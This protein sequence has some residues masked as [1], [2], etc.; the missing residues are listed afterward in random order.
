MG[1][2]VRNRFL[3]LCSRVCVLG[4]VFFFFDTIAHSQLIENPIGIQNPEGGFESTDPW[5]DSYAIQ[6]SPEYVALHERIRESAGYGRY[7]HVQTAGLDA[8]LYSDGGLNISF[9][10]EMGGGQL[11]RANFERTEDAHTVTGTLEFARAAAPDDCFQHYIVGL[12]S[13]ADGLSGYFAFGEKGY[14][15]RPAGLGRSV[16]YEFNA[17][18]AQTESCASCDHS[19][20]CDS[21]LISNSKPAEISIHHVEEENM[22]IRKF[23]T[24]NAGS[25][26]V[27]LAVGFTPEIAEFVDMRAESAAIVAQ[28]NHA[29][30]C[31]GVTNFCYRLSGYD[32]L[33]FLM[34]NG[35]QYGV[36]GILS[37]ILPPTEADIIQFR[38]SNDADQVLVVKTNNLEPGRGVSQLETAPIDRWRSVVI[39][40]SLSN[41]TPSHELAHNHGCQHLENV[42]TGGLGELNAWAKSHLIGP[43]GT[44]IMSASNPLPS[45][46]VRT[47]NFSNPDEWNWLGQTGLVDR[48]NAK[49]LRETGCDMSQLVDSYDPDLSQAIWIRPTDANTCPGDFSRFTVNDRCF[50]SS[51][52]TVSWSWSIN[53]GPFQYL[54]STSGPTI[55]L[56]LPQLSGYN[57]IVLKATGACMDGELVAATYEF[58]VSACHDPCPEDEVELTESRLGGSPSEALTNSYTLSHIDGQEIE[59]VREST[60]AAKAVYFTDV[61][62]RTYKADFVESSQ[63]LLISTTDINLQVKFVSVVTSGGVETFPFVLNK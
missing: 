14:V 40:G 54:Q 45:G 35:T 55:G 7:W 12:S 50:N 15:L 32:E 56:T 43:T 16:I 27:D 63:K 8:A 39:D 18:P 4:I 52:G 48:D 51:V 57:Y 3:N 11:T 30:L 60:D 17:P 47:F 26:V 41:Y 2:S 22:E 53:G 24:I 44:T 36:A 10:P 59:L 62:G 31:S 20:S 42:L 34:D 5:P 38:T 23:E 61:L 58:S 49:Q 9:P 37:Q 33:E 25:C 6:V 13:T 21:T 28:M 1:F 29:L 19:R 46:H